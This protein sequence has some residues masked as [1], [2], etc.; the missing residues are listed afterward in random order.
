MLSMFSASNGLVVGTAARA[1]PMNVQMAS[2]IDTVK[3]MQGPEIFWGSA[4]VAEGYDESD[5][6]G[7]DNFSMF[8][9]EVEKAG[10]D[11][12]GGDYTIL[13]PS[14]SA[15]EKHGTNNG[16]AITADILKYHV[17]P[18]KKSLEM[19]NADQPTL[20]GDTLKYDR[21]FRKNWLDNAIIGLKS[22]GP[23]KSSNWPADVE[24]DNGIIHAVDTILVPGGYTEPSTAGLQRQ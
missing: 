5:I 18:G 21:R 6:K 2:I 14:D 9:A 19:L 7:Y 20:Q 24:A 13:A 3:G 17:I 22:E 1:Q 4:G 15:F 16:C 12:S 8:V 11:L 23:S 10:I